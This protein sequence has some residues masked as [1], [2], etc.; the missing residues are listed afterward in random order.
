[1][2][3]PKQMSRV[4]VTGSKGVM[5]DV[6]EAVHDLSVVHITEY[7][8]GW[9]GFEP[10]DP[11]EGAEDAAQKLVTV[12]ALQSTLGVDEDDAG[13][14]RLVTEADIDEEVESIR[15]EVNELD[16]RRDTLG[17]EVREL[18]ERIERL[19]PFVRLGIDLD[20]LAG[21]DSLAVRVGEA[22]RAA[23]EDAMA[24]S[25][26]DA[27]EVFGED[28]VVAVVAHTDEET[29][30]DIVVDAEFSMLDVPAVETDGGDATDPAAYRDQLRDEQ[31]DVEAELASVEA[32]LESLREDVGGF[33]LSAEEHL[34]IQVE[35]QEAPL[36]FAT[37][38]NAFV[39][40]GW[41][42][43]EEF[44]SLEAALTDAVGDHV[45]VEELERASY[46]EDGKI[47]DHEEVEN[48]GEGA[49]LP[50]QA[51]EGADEAVAADG[52]VVTTGDDEP[53]TIM[54]N[55]SAAGPFELLVET[56]ERPRY[57]EFDPTVILWLT[58]PAFYGFMIGDVGYG[59]IY[60][61]IGYWMWK[62]FESD[63]IRSLG[64]IA[65]WAGGFTILFGV[66]YGEIFGLHQIGPLYG[67]PLI[68]KGI[69]PASAEDA[70]AWLVVAAIVGL[71]HMVIGY[72][73]DF[74][75]NISEGLATAFYDSGSWALVFVGIWV[76]VL[77]TSAK[78]AKPAFIYEVLNGHPL[79]LG[80]SGFSTTVGLAA[81]A[82]A[83]V[84]FL[85]VSIGEVR[86]EGAAGLIIAFL[87]G[88]V[89]ALA[90]VLSYARLVAVLLAKA[91]MALVVNLLFFGV[92]V[93]GHGEEAAFHYALGKMPAVGTMYHGHEVTEILFPGLVHGGI[94]SL[95]IGVVVLVLGHLLVL[96]LGVT[97]AGLQAVRLEYVEFM[98]KF[99]EGGGERYDPFGAVRR[100]TTEE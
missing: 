23:M 69:S 40:E 63:A 91:G 35:K 41:I 31:A 57:G 68:E 58:F 96:A 76:W 86:H 78:A 98:T 48:G 44:E 100:F 14:D 50:T 22:E 15:Q 83:G 28:G 30:Q 37:T 8:G 97:S 21:Y 80:F 71:G 73:F 6:I 46:D 59:I 84:G 61:A 70:R 89:G 24:A 43:A 88:I 54:D 3:R 60:T 52:G 95:V 72:I 13:P 65:M 77:S 79:P 75:K 49:D 38:E 42:P 34:A 10:G 9:E 74:F 4:S 11:A 92:Y 51:D 19:E 5:R 12:R 25:D 29:L 56:V 53:P 17:D 36:T 1:M 66:A 18:E 26:I 94:A 93:T 47:T 16:D 67:G 27:Y 90:N 45:L 82:V 87:E 62:T 33:L 2:F 39:A 99:F 81:L 55:P 32:D 7:D 85:G 20:L 64:G